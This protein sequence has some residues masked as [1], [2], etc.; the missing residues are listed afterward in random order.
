MEAQDQVH[1]VAEDGVLCGAPG[2]RV[3][4]SD[5]AAVTCPA[6]RQAQEDGR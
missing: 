6:C 4:T 2:V 5:R 1:R 3:A